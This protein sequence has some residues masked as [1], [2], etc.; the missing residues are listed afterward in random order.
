MT[1]ANKAIGESHPIR[2]SERPP[3]SCVDQ[4]V[5]GFC[6]W[7]DSASLLLRFAALVLLIC[8]YLFVAC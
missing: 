3:W 1:I 5:S 2:A 4:G 6:A 7:R 8:P